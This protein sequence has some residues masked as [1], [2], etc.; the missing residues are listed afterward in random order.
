MMNNSAQISLGSL[1]RVELRKLLKRMLLWV[2]LG[3][4]AL[5]V[6][7]IHLVIWVVLSKGPSNTLPPEALAELR[8][9]LYWPEGLYSALS[10]ANGGELGGMFIAILVGAFVAQEYTWHTVHFWLSRGVAR[11][12]YV[13]AK[14]V[15]VLLA[16]VL[17]V[18]TALVAGG[19]MTGV[20]TYIEKGPAALAHIAL[21]TLG[22]NVLRTTLTLLPYAA[23]TLL[24][25]VIS[26]STTV[27]I[28]VSMAYSL[29]VENLVVEMLALVSTQAARLSRFLPTMLAKSVMHMVSPVGN[30]QVG[31]E[32]QV[33]I[34]LLSP[35]IAA[36][37]LLLY[38][39]V[40]WGLTLWFFLRQD[41]TV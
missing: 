40:L 3:A 29:L 21:A 33:G 32:S 5:L 14:S 22:L 39:F 18:L 24:L 38:A 8:Q 7:F 36:A 16:L 28:G 17:L 26:R 35:N 15:A 9:G 34:P 10:F 12:Q 13:L 1:V 27:A 6:A 4:L 37:L 31:L 19:V 2:E 41:V 30:V 23:F 11:T 25:A 20:Y